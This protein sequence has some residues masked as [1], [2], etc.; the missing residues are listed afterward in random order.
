MEIILLLILAPV[1]LIDHMVGR[2]N[3]K[4]HLKN[5]KIIMTT[6]L[7][8]L[9]IKE[10]RINLAATAVPETDTA[11]NLQAGEQIIKSLRRETQTEPCS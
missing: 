1:L 10:V 11:T 4:R 2:V 8:W 3:T 6:Y 7:L 5:L 9:L